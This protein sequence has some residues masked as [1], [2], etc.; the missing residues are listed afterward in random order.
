[1]NGAQTKPNKNF[2][3]LATTQRQEIHL[4]FGS[5]PQE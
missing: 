4:S 1:M 2:S 5:E 3:W